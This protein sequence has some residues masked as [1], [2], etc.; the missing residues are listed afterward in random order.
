MA[1]RQTPATTP[2][3]SVENRFAAL[4]FE[5]PVQ[6]TVRDGLSTAQVDKI[7]TRYGLF[8]EAQFP[9][10]K[11]KSEKALN[12][13]L[14]TNQQV[15][16][17]AADESAGKK[18]VYQKR[19]ETRFELVEDKIIEKGTGAEA[20]VKALIKCAEFLGTP[21]TTIEYLHQP[22]FGQF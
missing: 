19:K 14:Q 4:E 6:P 5:A 15:I 17:M 9:G 12:E 16:E 13:L 10:I 3:T 2:D 21:K 11:V 1:K 20:P 8:T 22:N 7:K 18:D